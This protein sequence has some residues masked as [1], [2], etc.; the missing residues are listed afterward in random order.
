M[1]AFPVILRNLTESKFV[2]A[3]NTSDSLYNDNFSELASQFLLAVVKCDLFSLQRQRETHPSAY[4]QGC[5]A[6]V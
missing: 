5:Q 6:F 1:V 2:N 3:Q 4:T